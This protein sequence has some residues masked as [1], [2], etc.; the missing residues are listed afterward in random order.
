M[1]QQHFARLQLERLE[2]LVLPNMLFRPVPPLEAAPSDVPSLV[3]PQGFIEIPHQTHGL[4]L[5]LIESGQAVHHLPLTPSFSSVHS[6]VGLRTD[7]AEIED[8]R[9]A[10]GKG[11]PTDPLNVDF[12]DIDL[13]VGSKAQRPVS[14]APE[15]SVVP[16]VVN[17]SNTPITNT[18]A[19]TTAGNRHSGEHTG[20]SAGSIASINPFVPTTILL[21]PGNAIFVPGVGSQKF[22]PAS[23]LARPGFGS[24]PDVPGGGL[25]FTAPQYVPVNAD[26]DNG[27]PLV[28]DFP[29][30]PTK[31]DF[32][33]HPLPVNDPELIS[34]SINSFGLPGG[35][36]WSTSITYS[37]LGRIL[38]W[39]DQ[40]KTVL[41][42]P[43]GSFYVEG[44]HESSALNDVTL[45]FDYTVGGVKY[46]RSGQITV[47][48][49]IKTFYEYIWNTTQN[50][51]FTDANG[52]GGGTDATLGMTT[53][54]VI[55][56]YAVLFHAEL[57]DTSLSGKPVYIMNVLNVENGKQGTKNSA[58]N[59]VGATFSQGPGAWLG[60]SL[61]IT[62]SAIQNGAAFPLLDSTSATTPEYPLSYSSNDGNKA[63]IE[64]VD[65]PRIPP[66]A[67]P[68]NGTAIDVQHDMQLYLVW[69]YPSGIYYPLAYYKWWVAWDAVA[70]N[71][72]G[73]VDRI[74][75]KEG[76]F[77][78]YTWYPSNAT[79]GKMKG[80][81]ANDSV[82]WSY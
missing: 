48:P 1:R 38:L 9:L 81:L 78:D 70:T 25:A 63:T 39:V 27:S 80:P 60:Q 55:D 18:G 7:R 76:L 74:I 2:K 37:G 31:R 8:N 21:T 66:T 52:R 20:T 40:K 32:E 35:G 3:R 56:P 62:S 69:K 68:V 67:D 50:V 43:P 29:G 45:E 82:G 26:N 23:P 36:V 46:S 19:S 10:S 34:G 12:F 15:S 64:A 16:G 22:A 51:W 73:P 49:V 11:D 47:T 58:G 71:N 14:L 42:N 4:N 65:S 41:F 77:T 24:G 53:L 44:T 13:L 33:V 61:V 75:I 54:G 5:R 79:P 17:A 72:I 30:I 57:I 6:D 59:P 28:K